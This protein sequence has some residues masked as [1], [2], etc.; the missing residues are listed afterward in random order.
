MIKRSEAAQ[1]E[2]KELWRIW[3]ETLE[4]IDGGD[5]DPWD[6]YS[7]AIFLDVPALGLRDLIPEIVECEFARDFDLLG[8]VTRSAR[9]GIE[10]IEALTSELLD[11]RLPLETYT[12]ERILLW[13]WKRG[14]LRGEKTMAYVNRIRQIR[15]ESA[16]IE[17]NDRAVAD[18]IFRLAGRGN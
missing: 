18:F 14:L 16:A 12:T 10:K 5:G 6:R 1:S 13:E 11:R 8:E 4:H 17:L 7:L 9:I 15:D 3:W 2:W